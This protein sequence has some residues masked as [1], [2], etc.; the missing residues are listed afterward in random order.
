VREKESIHADNMAAGGIGDIAIKRYF[1][2]IWPIQIVH[3]MDL[4]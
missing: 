2:N 3:C 1:L 4:H